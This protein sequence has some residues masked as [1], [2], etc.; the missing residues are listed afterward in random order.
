MSAALTR[1]KSRTGKTQ[2]EIVSTLIQISN[3]PAAQMLLDI[4]KTEHDATIE[5]ALAH[6]K[7]SNEDMRQDFR[8][9]LGEASGLKKI[10]DAVS[11]VAKLAKQPE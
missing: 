11:A 1:Y 7:V 8:F 6:P 9:K 2:D 5:D 4:V 10:M 3:V